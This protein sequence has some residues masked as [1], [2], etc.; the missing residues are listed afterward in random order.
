MT[1]LLDTNVLS[2]ASKR[3]PGSCDVALLNPFKP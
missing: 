3:S 2:E 1:I